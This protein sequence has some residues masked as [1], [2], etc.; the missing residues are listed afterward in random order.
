MELVLFIKLFSA[1]IK[2]SE[3]IVVGLV[4]LL[5]GQRLVKFKNK[6]KNEMN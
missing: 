6:L 5:T 3:F 1:K 2:C 4:G